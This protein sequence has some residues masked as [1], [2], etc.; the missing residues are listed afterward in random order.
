MPDLP[1]LSLSQEHFDRV[2]AAFPGATL[3]QKAEA[4]KV[5]LSNR[6]IERVEAVESQRITEQANAYQRQA[7]ADLAASLPAR[8]ADP[9]LPAALQSP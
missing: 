2:V 6:L 9:P 4:Y 7:M 5:W 3:G 8:Q 1:A